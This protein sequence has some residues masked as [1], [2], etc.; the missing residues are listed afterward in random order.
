MSALARW[1]RRGRHRA[2]R[3][4]V[5]VADLQPSYRHHARDARGAAS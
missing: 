4:S 3:Y 1:L 2:N 5:R